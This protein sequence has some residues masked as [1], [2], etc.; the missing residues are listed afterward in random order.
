MEPSGSRAVLFAEFERGMESAI[1]RV[2]GMALGSYEEARGVGRKML[3]A[4]V[5]GL[6]VHCADHTQR[7]V[8]QAV[9]TVKVVMEIRGVGADLDNGCHRLNL[10]ERRPLNA[11]STRRMRLFCFEGGELLQFA[12]DYLFGKRIVGEGGALLLA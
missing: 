9:T 2:R 12:S 3:P 5:G 1:E 6:L 8:G 4:S 10:Y 11:A 7:H